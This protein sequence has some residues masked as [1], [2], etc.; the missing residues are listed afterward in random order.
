MLDFN[1]RRHDC[2]LIHSTVFGRLNICIFNVLVVHTSIKKE[3]NNVYRVLSFNIK[4]CVTIVMLPIK[5]TIFFEK[6]EKCVDM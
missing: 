2:R 1:G 6:D 5:T 3:G 4:Y